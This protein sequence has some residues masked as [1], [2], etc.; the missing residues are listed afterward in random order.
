MRARK[1]QQ[2]FLQTLRYCSVLLMRWF[3]VGSGEC[4]KSARVQEPTEYLAATGTYTAVEI[5]GIWPELQ[6]R[7]TALQIINTDIL[8]VDLQELLGPQL[9]NGGWW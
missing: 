4:W 8:Q 7:F 6:Q 5:V 2:H 3:E 1:R 9:T